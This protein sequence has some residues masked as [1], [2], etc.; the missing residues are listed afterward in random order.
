LKQK[1]NCTTAGSA[2]YS[3]LSLISGVVAGSADRKLEEKRG[4]LEQLK[5]VLELYSITYI[6]LWI[7]NFILLADFLI[8]SKAY[9]S[10]LFTDSL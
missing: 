10:F 2:R 1:K 9:L 4:K 5:T 7:A 8:F 6:I 3:P